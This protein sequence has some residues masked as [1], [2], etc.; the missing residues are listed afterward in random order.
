MSVELQTFSV[1]YLSQIANYCLRLS[2][3]DDELRVHLNNFSIP[4]NFPLLNY[5]PEKTSLVK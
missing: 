5:F 1:A 3:L 2:N 4:K